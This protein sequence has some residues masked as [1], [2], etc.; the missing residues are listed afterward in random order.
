LIILLLPIEFIILLFAFGGVSLKI[1]DFYGERGSKIISFISASFAALFFGLLMSHNSISSSIVLGIILGVFFSGK[2][3]QLNL[4]F[5]LILTLTITLMLNFQFPN[6][7]LLSIVTLFSFIDEL[8]H[9]RYSS[10]NFF[11]AKF[12]LLRPFL[13]TVFLIIASLSLLE[14]SYMLAFFSFDLSY[15]L[16]NFLLNRYVP[17]NK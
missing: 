5:G 10:K 9:D 12:L 13:K 17:Q 7:W 16:T 6:L 14:V 8:T 1:A 15:E 11:L 3:N 2:I 4:V